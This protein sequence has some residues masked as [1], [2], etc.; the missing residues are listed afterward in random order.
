MKLK[1][2]PDDFRVEELTRV[3]PGPA[4]PFAFY[5]L[6]KRGWTTPD[7]L[8]LLRR[9]WDV[10]PDR[11]SYG[12]L[13][14]RHAHTTQYLTVLRGPRRSL[15]QQGVVFEYLGQVAEPYAST[16]I[17]ANRF[18]VTLRSLSEEE[19]EGARREFGVV[20]EEGVPNYFDDQRFGSVTGPGGEFIARLLVRGRFEEAL[21][22]ALTAPY[23]HDRAAGK[24]EK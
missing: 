19:A 18:A 15:R 6:D 5:R 8:A 22:L 10:R 4:G 3:V 24:E 11:L 16:D 9:R 1:Q 2:Q 13:K 23:E 17:L 21:R 12:G 20:T 14:D 7:A